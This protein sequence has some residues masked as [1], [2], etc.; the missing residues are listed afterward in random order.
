MRVRSKL[1]PVRILK[2]WF[3]V[4]VVLGGA[5]TLIFLVWLAISPFLMAKGDIPVDATV[6][7]VVGER[8]W[9]PVHELELTPLDDSGEL[10]MD[11]ARLVKA[12]GE[13]RFLTTSWWLHFL[14]LG[15]IMLGAVIILY[16][17]WNLRKLLINVLDDRPFAAANGRILRQSGYILL[18][19]A[20]LWPVADFALSSFVLSRI[21]V[22][23]IHLRPAITLD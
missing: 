21:D 13:L 22:T 5:A 9:I 10:W 23:N 17:I 19:M 12:G 20:V 16:V 6:R 15:E 1:W 18:I 8:S 7:V 11:E 3:S 14:S 4:M 2:I